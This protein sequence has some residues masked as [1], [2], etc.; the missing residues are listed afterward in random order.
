MLGPLLRELW[1]LPAQVL[2]G[3]WAALRRVRQLLNYLRGKHLLL[4]LD[5]FEHLL[6]GVQLILLLALVAI[7]AISV[8]GAQAR[9]RQVAATTEAY[10]AELARAHRALSE[11]RTATARTRSELER[12][13]RRAE[14]QAGKR[15]RRQAGLPDIAA[16]FLVFYPAA[17]GCGG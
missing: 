4:L 2:P 7:L 10:R 17:P 6:E 8:R 9:R 16:S 3:F 12:E 13:R 14:Q 1:G 11:A 5:N 15:H